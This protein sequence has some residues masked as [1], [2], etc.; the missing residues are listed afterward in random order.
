MTAV[1][2]YEPAV[3]PGDRPVVAPLRTLTRRSWPSLSLRLVALLALLGVLT[4]LALGV[5]VVVVAVVVTA[6]AT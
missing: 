4:A 6:A 1:T 5:I 3:A 2:D